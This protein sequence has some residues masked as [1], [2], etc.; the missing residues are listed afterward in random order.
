[1]SSSKPSPANL[2]DSESMQAVMALRYWVRSTGYMPTADE[3]QAIASCDEKASM[4]WKAGATV[5]GIAGLG[6]TALGPKTV[7]LMQKIAV[8]GAFA[9]G[10]SFFGVFKSNKYCLN[11]ILS[12]ND[13]AS[14]SSLLE[15]S[16]WQSAQSVP[17]PLVAQAHQIMRDGPAATARSLKANLESGRSSSTVLGPRNEGLTERKRLL[18]SQQPLASESLGTRDDLPVPFPP[19]EQL[20]G[21]FPDMDAS[22]PRVHANAVGSHGDSW[23]AVRARYRSRTTADGEDAP[24]SFPSHSQP[25]DVF[26]EI[27]ST[28]QPRDLGAEGSSGDSWEA[29]RARYRSRQA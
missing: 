27:D 25:S 10:G 3:R 4:L 19:Q 15:D 5:G 26:P 24:V 28:Q 13:K 21:G 7:P 18:V 9:S 12:L 29:V 22:A 11:E 16:D 14:K 17:S 8:G 2:S 20:P 23:E 6:L 1:M